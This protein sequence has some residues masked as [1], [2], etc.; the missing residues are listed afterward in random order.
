[1]DV[2]S[3]PAQWIRAKKDFNFE[4]YSLG[5]SGV[6]PRVFNVKRGEE[7]QVISALKSEYDEPRPVVVKYG[8]SV[9]FPVEF[10]DE[11][12]EVMHH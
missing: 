12:F 11:V 10:T 4:V 9:P 2:L 1:M 7:F 3:L 5:Q 6:E 8:E